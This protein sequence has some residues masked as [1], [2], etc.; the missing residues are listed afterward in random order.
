M[1]VFNEVAERWYGQGDEF[2]GQ[3]QKP[4]KKQKEQ[5]A[6]HKQGRQ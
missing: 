6:E 1:R 4:V 3:D 5:P 2:F